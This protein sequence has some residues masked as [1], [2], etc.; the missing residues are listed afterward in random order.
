MVR[1]AHSA[2][3]RSRL[4]HV[5]SAPS[6]AYSTGCSRVVTH[7]GTNPARRCLT[8]MIRREPVCCRRLS[9]L[10]SIVAHK[11]INPFLWALV[12]KNVRTLL[13]VRAQPEEGYPT[14]RIC[15]I[16]L[17]KKPSLAMMEALFIRLPLPDLSVQ[18]DFYHSSGVNSFPLRHP[19]D[20][21]FNHSHPGC[22]SFTSTPPCPVFAT[23]FFQI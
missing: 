17:H 11:H 3:L 10:K 14:C 4:S 6:V 1:L 18:R 5:S 13:G 20:H 7:P 9:T 12:F 23:S 8:S 21:R 19:C 15:C 22:Q 16:L 2:D